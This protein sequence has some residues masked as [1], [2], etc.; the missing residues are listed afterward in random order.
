MVLSPDR[1]SL[2][3]LESLKL[4]GARCCLRSTRPSV[5]RFA[6]ASLSFCVPSSSPGSACSL[7][8]FAC[9]LFSV[10]GLKPFV[11]MA[12]RFLFHFPSDHLLQFRL[13][14]PVWHHHEAHKE[15]PHVLLQLRQF[16]SSIQFFRYVME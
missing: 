13:E 7:S 14:F 4:S 3:W 11:P 1:S 10:H 6:V 9:V 2:G 15:W 8:L 5:F 12:L 16:A